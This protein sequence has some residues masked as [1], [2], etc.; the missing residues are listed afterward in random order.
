[1]LVTV[2]F[3][4]LHC[5]NPLSLSLILISESL[6]LYYYYEVVMADVSANL[7]VLTHLTDID[8][9]VK[10]HWMQTRY[11]HHKV[12]NEGPLRVFLW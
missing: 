2:W 7:C 3:P 4:S 9:I 6:N 11:L 12:N 1:M 5:T 10:T 8:I